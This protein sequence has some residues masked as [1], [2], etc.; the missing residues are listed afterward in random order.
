MSITQDWTAPRPHA[1]RD[2]YLD[3]SRLIGM[4]RDMLPPE[5]PDG[6]PEYAP[7]FVR[8]KPGATATATR[9]ALLAQVE[10]AVSPLLMDSTEMA[11]LRG[12]IDDPEALAG[13]P[14]EYMLY[15]RMGTPDSD[16]ASLFEVLDTGMPVEI[17]T[18]GPL[19]E[20][21]APVPPSPTPGA[22]IVA[23]IDDGIGF[24]NARFCRSMTDGG[25]R[26]RFHGLW[27]QALEQHADRPRGAVS[28]RVLDTGAI[29]TLLAQGDE[30][31]A[32]AAINDALFAPG[33]RR[34]TAYA[35]THGTH[36]LDL[37]AGAEPGDASDPARDWPLLGVQLP[38]E[39]ID[40]TSGTWFES[41]LVL[42]LRW[43]L[44]QARQVDATAP[45]IVNVSLGVLAGPKD[46]SRFVE[47]QMARE[48][49]LWET[50]TGQ[51]VRLVWAFGNSYRSS[52]VACF[53]FDG[54]S[55]TPQA[56][57]WR[58]QPDDETASF[59]EIHLRG[60]ASDKLTVG[61]TSPEGRDSGLATLH[62]GEIRSLERP[63]GA[64]LARIY[65]VPARR[66]DGDTTC[67]AHYVLALAPTRGQ[68][69]DEPE[70]RAGAWRIALRCADK[71]DVLVQVQRD[72]AIRGSEVRGRQSYLDHRAAYDWD[73]LRAAYVA[74]GAGPITDD[75]CHSALVTAPA[76]QVLAV[77]AARQVGI[78]P[79]TEIGAYR[80]AA[81]SGQG[82]PWSVEGPTA[83]TV[84]G[85]GAF[86]GGVRAAGTLTG[87]TRRLA[88]TS[89][90]AGRMTRALA[91]SAALI[92]ENAAKPGTWQID[93]L[94][95]DKVGL[96]PTGGLHARLGEAVI[97]LPEALP[98]C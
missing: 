81:Y 72:D 61:L 16:H 84:A 64:A 8:L 50:V 57:T 89:A 58:A 33:T 22:P 59:V 67:S 49:R 91:L 15:R 40:D 7:V 43:I 85:I 52:Q 1:F 10:D 96:I 38:A 45:V 63:D 71:A 28:G 69:P 53:G 78:D 20:P 86:F 60:A 3:W 95:P 34:E 68:K 2:A 41:Y 65:H 62:P 97:D 6:G 98:A 70:A 88:G 17:D 77:G 12:R 66:C 31:A 90:A 54:T 13:L 94:D 87:S 73:P 47:Y 4:R 23:I 46:G 14:D 93:D 83:A 74:P 24:L 26:S 9:A 80:P 48:A 55:E 36:V 42:G 25:L 44:R 5:R 76:R 35:T 19:P 29:D 92:T 51:P 37:A 79:A 82:A 11:F 27:L 30:R 39:T 32:Y 56:I 75:G 21:P 18:A